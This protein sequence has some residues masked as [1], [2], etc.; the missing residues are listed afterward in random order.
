MCVCVCVCVFLTII[1]VLCDAM[2]LLPALFYIVPPVSS[3]EH[4]V[5]VE[6]Q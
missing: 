2:R 5:E 3:V 6:Q 1:H 4:W